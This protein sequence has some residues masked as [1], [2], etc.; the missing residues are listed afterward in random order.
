MSGGRFGLIKPEEQ[1]PRF[2]ATARVTTRV[3]TRATATL[4]EVKNRSENEILSNRLI[5]L[6]LNLKIR[7]I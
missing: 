2:R 1:T 4:A 7:R 5:I 3:T 6:K